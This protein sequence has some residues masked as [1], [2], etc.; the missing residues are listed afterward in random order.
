MDR[1]AQWAQES[2]YIF[3][4]WDVLLMGASQCSPSLRWWDHNY[5]LWHFNLWH[6]HAS[7]FEQLN[8][9]G[10]R[11]LFD[12]TRGGGRRC[13]GGGGIVKSESLLCSLTRHSNCP[14]N[15]VRGFTERRWNMSSEWKCAREN[16]KLLIG[17]FALRYLPGRMALP[18]S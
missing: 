9:Y 11:G 18:I 4:L 1:E 16:I 6:G 17:L 14:F 2:R 5:S 7:E 12:E 15:M 8:F 3:T 10:Q 13:Q